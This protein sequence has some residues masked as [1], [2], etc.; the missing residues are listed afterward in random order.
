MKRIIL[1]LAV[2]VIL[3]VPVAAVDVGNGS[4]D[5]AADLIKSMDTYFNNYLPGISTD[6][7]TAVKNYAKEGLTKNKD[8][9]FMP[10][11]STLTSLR[12]AGQAGEGE[13]IK[14]VINHYN[15]LSEKAKNNVITNLTSSFKSIFLGVKFTDGVMHISENSREIAAIQFNITSAG[16]KVSKKS[17]A[18]KKKSNKNNT[19]TPKKTAA[20]KSK[21]KAASS[22]HPL[23]DTTKGP[24]SA[25]P[26]KSMAEAAKD[27]TEPVN[28]TKLYFEAYLP[29]VPAEYIDKT[30]E[31]I[32]IYSEDGGGPAGS[33]A[34]WRCIREI[35]ELMG[36]EVTMSAD[37]SS[38]TV[39]K[40]GE[41]EFMKLSPDMQNKIIAK[42]KEGMTGIA[43][44]SNYEKGTFTFT[45][46]GK[47]QFTYTVN[48][49]S[50]IAQA[51]VKTDIANNS[52]KEPSNLAAF[53]YIGVVVFA[54]GAII[55]FVLL[56]NKKIK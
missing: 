42:V 47:V 25:A 4:G 45:K 46:L 49:T 54:L 41:T 19:T 50:E 56:K 21:Q 35:A 24:K 38:F 52:V 5:D 43:V 14:D 17:T 40:E 13:G 18:A 55:A 16:V 15:K 36:R 32:R 20:K 3:A 10:M 29:A 12:K 39:I 28:I 7:T 34:L 48:G 26:N 9:Y 22:A 53:I 11:M 2:A 44:T 31:L 1:A 6:A 33:G 23:P 30:R 27:V 51:A 8:K 37:Y